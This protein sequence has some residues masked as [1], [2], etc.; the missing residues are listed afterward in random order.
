VGLK[1]SGYAT[2]PK[3]AEQLIA[4]IEEFQ[5]NQYDEIAS[6]PNIKV[7]LKH[8]KLEDIVMSVERKMLFN[9]LKYVIV[10][11]DESFYKVAVDNNIEMSDLYVYN[12]IAVSDRPYVGQILY[13]E[14]KKR[15][16]N[17]EFHVV[18]EGET[19]KS[20][21]QFHGVKL[22]ELYKRNNLNPEAEPAVGVK[23]LLKG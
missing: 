9:G 2:E 18:Q 17:D 20:I 8:Q 23:L 21:A 16:S 4:I 6:L 3:Y 5:L 7:Q 1:K 22:K 13:L 15:S 19:M 10:K 14:P 12:D 11:A